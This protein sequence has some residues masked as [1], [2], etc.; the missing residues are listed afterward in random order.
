MKIEIIDLE[1]INP[2]F[3]M[4][5]NDIEV[6]GFDVYRKAH[7]TWGEMA[8]NALVVK[9]GDEELGRMLNSSTMVPFIEA[10]D[11]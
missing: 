6:E 10:P 3:T 8:W 7:V 1:E 2:T 9:H 4:D 11:A 5:I